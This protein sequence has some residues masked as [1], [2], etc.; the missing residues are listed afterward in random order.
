MRT[1]ATLALSALL[2]GIGVV[3]VVETAIVGGQIGYLF[4]A[5]FILAG[6]LRVR[7]TRLG[8]SR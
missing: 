7:L 6:V 4:G 8:R 3:L 1:R 5:L 2:V